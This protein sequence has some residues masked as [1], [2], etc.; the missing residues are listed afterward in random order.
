MPDPTPRPTVVVPLFCTSCHQWLLYDS[1]QVGDF[2]W[3]KRVV[4]LVEHHAKEC[5]GQG[6]TASG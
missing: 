4:A 6:A 2:E 5:K 3:D 1:I